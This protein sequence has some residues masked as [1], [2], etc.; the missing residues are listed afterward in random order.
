MSLSDIYSD[1]VAAMDAQRPRLIQLLD[2]HI[3]FDRLIPARFHF[4]FYTGQG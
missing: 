4:A 3:D 1:V 2:D